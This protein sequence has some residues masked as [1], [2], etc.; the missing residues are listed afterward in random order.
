MT[1]RNEEATGS[2]VSRLVAEAS[3][4]SIMPPF[5]SYSIVPKKSVFIDRKNPY[6]VN[7]ADMLGPGFVAQ[8]FSSLQAYTAFQIVYV[9]AVIGEV[10]G[11]YAVTSILP[12]TVTYT[13]VPIFLIR[14]A[15]ISLFSRDLLRFLRKETEF[16]ILAV[17]LLAATV[18]LCEMFNF[19]SY[20]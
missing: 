8:R 11:S 1:S 4:Y 6:Y 9:L 5:A 12:T 20:T 16:R 19:V 17:V 13:C 2:C 14:L 3:D 10:C 18:S 15:S 7:D